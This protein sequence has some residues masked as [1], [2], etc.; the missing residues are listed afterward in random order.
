MIFAE[1]MQ[2]IASGD[3]DNVDLNALK[4]DF[5]DLK[6][7]ADSAGQSAEIGRLEN[8]GGAAG[9]GRTGDRAYESG[10]TAWKARDYR[11]AL[12]YFDLAAAG[13]AN[14]PL[15]IT[16]GRGPTRCWATERHAGRVRLALAAGFHDVSALSG[17]EFKSFQ[18]LEV[19]GAGA[20]W[21][22]GWREETG[23]TLSCG[24]TCSRFLDSP[25]DDRAI[26]RD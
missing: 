9:A 25:R 19:S 18:G 1:Q 24:A 8:A 21:E 13:S 12:A 7:R 3:S 4:H 10:S 17:G 20:E 16:R 26:F 23:P 2:A 5:A 14:P 15:R 22:G 11:A 6:K